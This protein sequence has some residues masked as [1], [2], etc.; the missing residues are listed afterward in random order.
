MEQIS[1]IK[2]NGTTV[3]LFSKEPY[4][5]VK[6]ARQSKT[7]M[8]VDTVTLSIISR[9]LIA[10]AKGDKIQVNGEDYF[11]RTAVNRELLPDN[12]FKYDVVFYGVLYDLM[13]TPYRDMDSQGKSSRN[14]FD[15]I[16][17][18]KQFVRVI[19]NNTNVD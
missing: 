4:R 11:I 19:I 10:F 18:L 12:S 7:L 1:L 6:Q 13:K 17:T 9:D 15:L 5:T 2:R 3:K 16:Y 8:G 14:T